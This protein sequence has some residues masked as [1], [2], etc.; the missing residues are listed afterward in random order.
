MHARTRNARTRNALALATAVAV[1]A[2]L[3]TALA[4]PALAAGTGTADE[5][6][7]PNPGRFLPRSEQLGQA[8]PEGYAHRQGGGDGWLWTDTRTGTDRQITQDQATKGHSG[9]SATVEADPAVTA[10]R[11]KVTDVATGQERLDLVLPQGRKFTGAFAAD[12]VVTSTPRAD[13]TYLDALQLLQVVDGTP[14]ERAVTPLTEAFAEVDVLQ[15]DARGA[16]LRFFREPGQSPVDYVLDYATATLKPT[17]LGGEGVYTV[18]GADRVA[19]YD[20]FN[21]R[22]LTAPRD[23]PKQTHATPMPSLLDTWEA[24]V[25]ITGEWVLVTERPSQNTEATDVGHALKAIRIGTNDVIDL[26][27][28]A[29]AQFATAPDGSVLAVGGT[30]AADW[31]VHRVTTGEDGEP[32]LTKVS[33]IPVAPA[34]IGGL[35]LGGGRLNFLS[36]D[37]SGIDALGLHDVDTDLTTTPPTAGAPSL[38]AKIVAPTTPGLTA[39]GD[40]ESVYSDGKRLYSRTDGATARTAD[41]PVADATVIDGAGRYA[42]AQRGTTLYV[43][44]L[45]NDGTTAQDVRHTVTGAAA[46]L[47]GTKVWKPAATAGQVVAYDLEARLTSAPVDLGSGCAP[48]ELQAV[49]RWLYWACGADKAGVYDRTAKKSVPVPAGE[50]LLGDG[51]VVRHDGDKLKLTNAV[52]GQTTDLADLP[53]GMGSG[54]RSTWTVDKFGGGVAFVDAEKNLHVKKAG[55]A[56]QDLTQLAHTV[57]PVTFPGAG[58]EP[59]ASWSPVFRFSKPVASTW[60]LRIETSNGHPVRT[61]DGSGTAGAAVRPVW[62]GKDAQ[63]RGIESGTYR[64]KLTVRAKDTGAT[65]EFSGENLSVQ[66]SS[67]TT[68]PAR[69]V[70]LTP[71]RVMDT[72]VGQGGVTLTPGMTYSLG[73][74]GLGGV[75][76][77]GVT[78]VV[79]NVTAT[80]PTKGGFVSVFPGE[81]KR[82]SAST[83]NF[84]A[85]QTVSNLV[86]VPVNAGEVSF[87]NHLGNTDLIADVAGYYTDGAG[88]GST[89][90]PVA[91]QRLMD[92]RVGTGVPKAK[93]Q[94]GGTVTL[95]VTEPGVTAVALNVTATNATSASFISAYPYGTTRPNVSN[96]NFGAGQTVPNMAVVPVKDGKITFY[97]RAGSVDVI[98]DVAGYFKEGTGAVFTGMQ[99]K[100]L[101]DTRDGTGVAKA[102]VGAGGTVS[103]TVGTTYKAVVLN[104]TATNPTATGFVSV[105]P[106][107]TP[108]SSASNLNF[109][110]GQT[111]PNGVIVPVKDGKITFYNHTGTVDLIADVTGYYTD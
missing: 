13:G 89:Y 78:A 52:S 110:A 18:L 24:A 22:V 54:R 71:T 30:G 88:S 41:L 21:N 102:K 37:V 65:S 43:A 85:G 10:D 15:Q 28:H 104:V 83:L 60:Q 100:R 47:W 67:L 75:P 9:L 92:T 86:T 69:F 81:T 77:T 16:L 98:A 46:A 55:V 14:T 63:G 70:P 72:R 66:G 51:F 38:R 64:W 95:A 3:C 106:Y 108:R 61:I 35:A 82:T 7:I 59:A 26:L 12:T 2:G 29:A 87:Y 76:K 5:V 94:G 6:V 49:E 44:D 93:I 105:Y 57:G 4:T 107:G 23:N 68:P 90:Q 27:P 109:V 36:D 56:T 111:V 25:A 62:D 40:G 45:D 32:K 74:A 80:K 97:N 101:M 99:P 33:A 11:V 17:A 48:T 79:L 42:L 91:P 19:S 1:S 34:R 31:A 8:G 84:K 39:L 20:T 50:A 96:V 58:V 53:A 73:V 103:L